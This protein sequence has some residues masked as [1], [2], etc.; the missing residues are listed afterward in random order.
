[1]SGQPAQGATTVPSDGTPVSVLH[2]SDTRHLNANQPSR[3]L[4]IDNQGRASMLLL[5]NEQQCLLESLKELKEYEVLLTN[6]H[7]NGIKIYPQKTQF[8]YPLPDRCIDGDGHRLLFLDKSPSYT[9]TD[10]PT[11]TSVLKFTHKRFATEST[12]RDPNFVYG[13]NHLNVVKYNPTLHGSIH[14]KDWYKMT[15]AKTHKEWCEGV[16]T[17][18]VD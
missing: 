16:I 7:R 14:P 1:M 15:F 11:T 10:T 4:C 3:A 17:E 18:I 8:Y 12:P 9:A 5:F 6:V 13:K 2:I